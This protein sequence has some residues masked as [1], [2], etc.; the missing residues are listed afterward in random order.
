MPWG[1]P[2]YQAPFA[3]E[4]SSVGILAAVLFGLLA[5]M[6]KVWWLRR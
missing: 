2:Q 5:G 4:S 6:A 3:Q 1:G